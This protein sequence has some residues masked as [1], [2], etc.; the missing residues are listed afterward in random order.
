MMG[1]A[2]KIHKWVKSPWQSLGSPVVEGPRQL[3]IGRSLRP[4]L[5]KT[6]L[7]HR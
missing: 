2:A 1:G 5:A 7:H 3:S 6:G 4:A